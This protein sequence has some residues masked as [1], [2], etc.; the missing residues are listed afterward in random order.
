MPVN[1]ETLAAFRSLLDAA[2]APMLTDIA[3]LKASGTADPAPAD[4]AAPT[5]VAEARNQAA[6]AVARAKASE[7]ALAAMCARPN[8]VGRSALA[9]PDGPAAQGAYATLIGRARTDA[10]AAGRAA[11]RTAGSWIG[12][13]SG[14]CATRRAGR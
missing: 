9:I 4:R 13:G 11:S 12:A 2:L 3:A 8:R 1:E 6:A 7:D 14:D 10:S 5:Q